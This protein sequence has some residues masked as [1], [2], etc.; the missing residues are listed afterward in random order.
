MLTLSGCVSS[1]VTQSPSGGEVQAKTANLQVAA[2]KRL[3]LGLKYLANGNLERAKF[4]LD[5]A[6]QHAPESPEVLVGLAYYYQQ[7]KEDKLAEE[8]YQRSLQR[9]PN[10]GDNINSYASFLCSKGNYKK[11]QALFS[12]A[13][14]LADYA[15]AGGSYENMGIC[16]KRAGNNQF[17]KESFMKALNYNANSV[18]SLLEMADLSFQEKSFLNARAFLRQYFQ[19]ATPGARALWLGIQIE[20][21]LGDSDALSS[22]QLQLTGRFPDADETKL[23]LKSLNK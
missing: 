15:G 4:N 9:A 21:L 14:A 12:K 20:R 19:G 17:A 13:I 3:T 5:R 16:A 8:Y 7:V 1:T 22:Y 10:D 23:Y 18:K 2:H 11:A 6:A